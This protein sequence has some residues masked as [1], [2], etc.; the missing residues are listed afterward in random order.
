MTMIQTFRWP[1]RGLHRDRFLVIVHSAMWYALDGLVV[2]AA[3]VPFIKV[4]T[5]DPHA[6]IN[7]FG[8]VGVFQGTAKK[9]PSDDDNP[10]FAFKLALNR[11][12]R[13]ALEA[14]NLGDVWD[15]T[16]HA[17]RSVPRG[18]YIAY[19]S[20]TDKMSVTNNPCY[21]SNIVALPGARGDRDRILVEAILFPRIIAHAVAQRATVDLKLGFRC[22][23]TLHYGK[24]N[25]VDGRKGWTMVHSWPKSTGEGEP[26]DFGM[27]EQVFLDS[28]TAAEGFT[29]KAQKLLEVR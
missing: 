24:T 22:N 2:Y 3:V 7:T 28:K 20:G 17:R 10:E 15:E 13:K 11:A 8:D 29:A 27:S 4:M 19:V 5:F 1:D 14:Q 18:Y 23:L 21:P 9:A 12:I 16:Y 25:C 6:I 26:D